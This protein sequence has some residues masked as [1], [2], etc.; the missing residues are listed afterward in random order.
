M[1]IPNVNFLWPKSDPRKSI[2]VLLAL[3]ASALA[4]EPIELFNGKD[5]SGWKTP[6]GTWSAV[7]SVSLDPAN[8][9]AFLSTPG[10]G[11]LLNNSANKTLNLETAGEWGDCELHVEFC[12]PQGSNSGIYLQ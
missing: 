3:T 4:A 8:N 7:Q 10:S 2:P 11:V 5:L 1:T 9:K 6:T 12:V